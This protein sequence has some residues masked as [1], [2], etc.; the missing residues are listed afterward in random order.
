MNRSISQHLVGLVSFAG[1]DN[2]IARLSMAQDFSNRYLAVRLDLIPHWANFESSFDFS[3]D[4]HRIFTA[5]V[6]GGDPTE[7]SDLFSNMCHGR[8]LGTIAIASTAKEGQQASGMQLA[9]C[10]QNLFQRVR[11]VSIVH[12]NLEWLTVVEPFKATGNCRAILDPSANCISIDAQIRRYSN[13]CQDIRQ[14]RLSHQLCLHF[15]RDS[16]CLQS[17]PQSFSF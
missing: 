3:E 14:V 2:S 6:V 8:T 10:L 12:E 15:E 16:R 9:G 4:L 5:W 7:I 13:G 17:H 11:R 1:N